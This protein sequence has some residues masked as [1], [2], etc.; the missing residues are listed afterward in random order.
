MKPNKNSLTTKNLRSIARGLV[1]VMLFLALYVVLSMVFTPKVDGEPGGMT[2]DITYSYRAESK[3]SVDVVFIGNSDVA[4]GINPA[5]IY[6]D[7]GITSVTV[8]PSAVDSE[9][10]YDLLCDIQKYQSPKVIALEVDCLYGASNKYYKMITREYNESQSS[11][12]TIKDFLSETED[13]IVSGLA[14][15]WPV[16][17]Y[18]DRWSTLSANDFS[19]LNGRYKYS[20]KGYMFTTERR[21]FKYGDEYM[22]EKTNSA[23]PLSDKSAAGFEKII[24]F[25]KEN[26]IKLALF[27]IPSGSS[28]TP[29]KHNGAVNLAQKYSLDFVDY[30]TDTFLLDS[31]SWLNDTKDGGNHMNYY[32]AT[33]VTAAYE[34]HLQSLFDLKPTALSADEQIVWQ[35]DSDR[36]YNVILKTYD[37]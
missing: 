31:F 33:K 11:A 5:Q 32:G 23:K 37:E 1:F 22:S 27:A 30:N 15:Y 19:N 17:K 7:T 8:G 9:K 35:T 25:C 14:F 6:R 2:N 20:A 18:H 29:Q 34:K 3:N 10:V 4:R 24:A 16:M 21:G 28:W 12:A 36:F 13:K 26:N